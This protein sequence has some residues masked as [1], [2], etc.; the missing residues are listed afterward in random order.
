MQIIYGNYQPAVQWPFS[1]TFQCLLQAEIT[2]TGR[3]YIGE[4]VTQVY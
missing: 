2:I 4:V 3:T 1:N